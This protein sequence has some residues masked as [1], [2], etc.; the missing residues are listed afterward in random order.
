VATRAV[1]L[2]ALGTLVELEPPWEHLATELGVD[3]DERLVGAVRGEMDYYK[4]HAH[5]GVDEPSLAG[6]RSRC[7]AVLS[8]GLGREVDVATMMRAI[9]FRAFDDAAP[10][11]SA[12]R[13]LGLGLACVS[14]WDI[15]LSEVLERCGLGG[16]LDAVVSS[17]AAGARK[18]DPAIFRP[19]LDATGCAPGEALHVGDTPEEDIDAANA[20]GIPALLLNRAG[21]GG[22][23]SLDEIQQHLRP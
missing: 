14:N 8:R 2:D 9:R 13:D 4:A 1:F 16:G 15:S 3:A 11:L 12:L 19:A 18:P 20:A 6:L 22:I 7:A 21:D 5:E 23:A 17:A 10:A